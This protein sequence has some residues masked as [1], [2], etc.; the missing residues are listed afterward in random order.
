[1]H[2]QELSDF[3]ILNEISTGSQYVQFNLSVEFDP[4]QDKQV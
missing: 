4:I 3:K 2:E 1:M